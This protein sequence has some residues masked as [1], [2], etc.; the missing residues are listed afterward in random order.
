METTNRI[1]LT[2]N[3]VEKPKKSEMTARSN[4]NNHF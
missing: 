2:L 4:A 1:E 3:A